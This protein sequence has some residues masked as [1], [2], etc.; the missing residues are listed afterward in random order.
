M[1]E[2]GAPGSGPGVPSV[3]GRLTGGVVLGRP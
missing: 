1:I 2:E 3:W